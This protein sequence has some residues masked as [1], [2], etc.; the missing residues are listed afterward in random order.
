MK[1]YDAI[2][3]DL[4]GTL[5]PMDQNKFM[6]SYFGMLA[7]KLAPYGYAP[8]ELIGAIWKGS[9][10]MVLNDGKKTNECVFWDEFVK[11]YGKG[12]LEHYSVFEDFYIN[13][14]DNVKSSCGFDPLAV[15]TV[16]E[17]KKRGFRVALATNPLFPREATECRIRW[18][19][20]SPNDFEIYTTYENSSF[21]KPNL[22]YYTEV[23]EKL[24]VKADECL[25]VG[26]DVG[27]DMI[28]EKLGM[29]VFLVTNCLINKSNVDISAFPH[30][31]LSALLN[32][33]DQLL[34][35]N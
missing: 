27:E 7:K 13:D 28:V 17:L 35:V 22:A 12:I 32:F 6:K 8:D 10:A 23:I 4:D 24:G 19:G 20:L 1:K 21:C 18:T 9:K 14:F 16:S 5:L 11:I 15:K 3:F 33:V 31:D 26:N 34:R 2:L 30:G 25:M 29:K